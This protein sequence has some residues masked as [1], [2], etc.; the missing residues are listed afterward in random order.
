MVSNFRKLKKFKGSNDSP[1]RSKIPGAEAMSFLNISEDILRDLSEANPNN[2]DFILKGKNFKNDIIRKV[3]SWDDVQKISFLDDSI[4]SGI[5]NF[6]NFMMKLE[7]R[8]KED[9]SDNGNRDNSGGF[10]DI[11]DENF[12]FLTNYLGK[13]TQQ[14][15]L[16]DTPDY[17]A[18]AIF[19][20][21]GADFQ[22]KQRVKAF[23][24]N[25]AVQLKDFDFQYALE[26]AKDARSTI[27]K[28][29]GIKTPNNHVKG[30]IETVDKVIDNMFLGIGGRDNFKQKV[31][32]FGDFLRA[33]LEIGNVKVSEVKEM[34]ITRQVKDMVDEEQSK[35][36]NLRKLNLNQ[37]PN[38]FDVSEMDEDKLLVK[39]LFLT[40][41]N[42]I[43]PPRKA[44][45]QSPTQSQSFEFHFMSYDE[46]TPGLINSDFFD[47]SP[48]FITA[49][50]VDSDY[51]PKVVKDK[52]R[53]TFEKEIKMV[54]GLLDKAKNLYDVIKDISP[55]E[56]VGEKEA[57]KIE[58]LT[59]GADIVEGYSDCEKRMP[60]YTEQFRKVKNI[61]EG[62]KDSQPV[63]N[64][65]EENQKR[66]EENIP[67]LKPRDILELYPDYYSEMHRLRMTCAGLMHALQKSRSLEPEESLDDL[68]P[69]YRAIRESLIEGR[70]VL[71]TG[72]P[73][74][75]IKEL[76]S[77]VPKREVDLDQVLSD[78]FK[79]IKNLTSAL[80]KSR[81]ETH[82]KS[83][84]N[85]YEMTARSAR[86]MIEAAIDIDEVIKAAKNTSFITDVTHPEHSPTSTLDGEKGALQREY[87]ASKDKFGECFKDY[88]TQN[89][90]KQN[91]VLGSLAKEILK[92]GEEVF[93]IH[94]NNPTRDS[95]ERNIEEFIEVAQTTLLNSNDISEI[96]KF[97]PSH[98]SVIES[99]RLSNQEKNNL[100]K[101]IIIRNLKKMRSF[102][103]KSR[104]G[105]SL[106][107]EIE[108]LI[109]K[110]NL[111]KIPNLELVNELK[112]FLRVM[113][114]LNHSCRSEQ[115]FDTDDFKQLRSHI[116]E[117]NNAIDEIM[118]LKIHNLMK[119]VIERSKILSNSGKKLDLDFSQQKDIFTK[120]M[121]QVLSLK[122]LPNEELGS[123]DKE[124][125]LVNATVYETLRNIL[126]A[127]DQ[128]SKDLIQ[129]LRRIEKTKKLKYPDKVKH[130][131]IGCDDI[132]NNVK[133]EYTPLANKLRSIVN[134]VREIEKSNAQ[135]QEMESGIGEAMKDQIDDDVFKL[136]DF[137]LDLF[138]L[139]D[140]VSTPIDNVILN[141]ED[142]LKKWPSRGDYN[143][144]PRLRFSSR[145]KDFSFD[146]DHSGEKKKQVEEFLK[147]NYLSR[148]PD[149]VFESLG[150]RYH[151][152]AGYS[153]R[154]KRNRY[155]WDLNI[156]YLEQ[157][158]D[159]QF[160][161][162]DNGKDYS[163][164]KKP[165]NKIKSDLDSSFG[166][167][168]D[169][170]Q[171]L[172]KFVPVL[173]VDIEESFY[174]VDEEIQ[175]GEKVE[176]VKRLIHKISVPKGG[177]LDPEILIK[178]DEF[179][180]GEDDPNEWESYYIAAD[181]RGRTLP[182]HNR[183]LF[184]R[185][186]RRIKSA[187]MLKRGA[188]KPKIASTFDKGDVIISSKLVPTDEWVEGK[189]LHKKLE[190][191]QIVEGPLK[192]K[193]ELNPYGF[194]IN[195]EGGK[196]YFA[197]TGGRL[198]EYYPRLGINS[199][200]IML[201][202]DEKSIALIQLAERS[203]HNP[204]VSIMQNQK[205]KSIPLF[206]KQ[207]NEKIENHPVYYHKQFE[208]LKAHESNGIS[209][210]SVWKLDKDPCVEILNREEVQ[211]LVET[212]REKV[213]L[214]FYSETGEEIE[215]DRVLVKLK[216][217]DI[218]SR[219]PELSLKRKLFEK[220]DNSRPNEDNFDVVY[221]PIGKTVEGNPVY[222]R[223]LIKKVVK[224]V[225]DPVISSKLDRI[226]REKSIEFLNKSQEKGAS[227]ITKPV[228]EGL[229]RIDDHHAEET[230]KIVDDSDFPFVGD[231]SRI[232]NKSNKNRLI[233]PINRSPI[234]SNNPFEIQKNS[235]NL[236]I[237]RYPQSSSWK[238]NIP[239]VQ[240]DQSE[241]ESERSEER[242]ERFV[243]ILK[244]AKNVPDAVEIY[245]KEIE[246][247]GK[248]YGLFREMD[249]RFDNLAME[250]QRRGEKFDD[251][252]FPPG[253]SS[254]VNNTRKTD[255]DYAGLEWKSIN[256]EIYEV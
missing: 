149:E 123:V 14:A 199:S 157:N 200:Y 245:K 19:S 161:K 179:I 33:M 97:L 57:E 182:E 206:I 94:E 170:N 36:V 154:R 27:D 225:L 32:D 153:T 147:E 70:E 112:E 134:R 72:N 59:R 135:I 201:Q 207:E 230:I 132:C 136:G 38:F 114:Q 24:E 183:P 5:D 176:V 148:N 78:V 104:R 15:N 231:E 163:T 204:I 203:S 113:D 188:K 87:D 86:N 61:A 4:L 197:M 3:G 106:N 139:K 158:E 223:K 250:V 140:A 238:E 227:R 51:E 122:N 178:G 96:P 119:G 165:G 234:N 42:E 232:L 195:C 121:N 10:E 92:L 6:G 80:N 209:R 41:A 145:D 133:S 91:P 39:K 241:S 213:P 66:K 152:D 177:D 22:A 237:P 159:M 214:I 48:K 9:S 71:N 83:N 243:E 190:S 7:P 68:S 89:F 110:F 216:L 56:I 210:H 187:E 239:P 45:I 43:L 184:K 146:R 222:L 62:R 253:G 95:L 217:M 18:V 8:V 12:D 13:I 172:G 34:Q 202:D 137:K 169:Q 67:V 226:N 191:R 138:D 90:L 256:E 162:D 251:V 125:K 109:Y 26:M 193:R 25:Y 21:G 151:S 60:V 44:R 82:E 29:D 233:S 75:T 255:K 63:F 23:L 156:P 79:N 185:R 143:N 40:L 69:H 240:V 84:G 174:M 126:E 127:M 248:G 252:S 111:S 215:G 180:E 102:N 53:L 198:K 130:I 196:P 205:F 228:L 229:S 100:L 99:N 150:Q 107:E 236:K 116:Y 101:S 142:F 167:S 155:P 181:E 218:L 64:Q 77:I 54:N 98:R 30:I 212:M 50:M 93:Q 49:N 65:F 129:N 244:E 168:H 58:L 120:I 192:L 224:P 189:K 166:V 85:G 131:K 103:D 105:D 2:H 115:I 219:I 76:G 1:L 16:N 73:E 220:V 208:K 160:F 221:E 173:T 20:P 124:L 108:N 117:A 246:D 35:L 235:K 46:K 186:M 31:I 17:Q 171:K 118:K 247:F 254:M 55:M 164:V 141:T 144:E 88:P 211:K 249:E 28:I 194:F 47:D 128:K 37:N 175:H 81:S 52:A 74:N 242:A 11:G